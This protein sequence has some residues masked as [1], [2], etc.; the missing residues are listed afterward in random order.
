M[1]SQKSHLSYLFLKYFIM[2]VANERQLRYNAIHR[3]VNMNIHERIKEARKELG[4][5]VDEVA[6]KLGVSRA[7]VYRYESADIENMGIDK[8]EP[9]ARVLQTTPSHLMGWDYTE[10]KSEQLIKTYITGILAWSKESVF[11]PAETA[12]IKEHLATLLFR[13]K[14][15]V[16]AIA[17]AK[18]DLRSQKDG[19]VDASIFRIEEKH[20]TESSKRQIDDLKNWA[21]NLP[22]FIASKMPAG[23]EEDLSP[24]KSKSD[25]AA[26]ELINHFSELNLDGK[27]AALD[28]V[29]ALTYVPKYKK[30]DSISEEEA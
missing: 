28:S 12:A 4:L 25:K 22:W 29:E 10:E 18:R 6:A 21:A 13:Y 9:L 27:M 5:S 19:T 11:D 30:C 14:L 26:E 16:E 7:T 15:A 1:S 20:F 2:G 24:H 17:N 3:G 8:I 23:D